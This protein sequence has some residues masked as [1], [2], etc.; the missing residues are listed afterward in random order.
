MSPRKET[1]A[2]I[3]DVIVG[4]ALQVC[5]IARFQ[6]RVGYRIDLQVAQDF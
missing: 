3:V 1:P 4:C 6:V 5:I 2:S